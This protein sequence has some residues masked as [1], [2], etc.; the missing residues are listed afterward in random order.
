MAESIQPFWLASARLTSPAELSDWMRSVR[1]QPRWLDEVILFS[2]EQ[3]FAIPP[4]Q[5]LDETVMVTRHFPWHT[6]QLSILHDA[7]RKINSGDRGMILILSVSA[8][9]TTAII[10][11][12]PSKTG[13][14]NMMPLAYMDVRLAL[15][16]PTMNIDI[17]ETIARELAA[18][19]KSASQLHYLAFTSATLKRP[20][21][22]ASPFSGAAWVKSEPGA[23]ASALAACH[24]LVTQLATTKKKH[25]LAFE[26][27]TE[28]NLYAS[29]IEMV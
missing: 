28:S 18:T 2:P 26:I 23:E 29:W 27:D 15:H 8:Q 3:E 9:A 11:C 16:L 21:K 6:S 10:L 4:L 24:D 19:E 22:S 17:L 14:Y 13:M 12:S 25:G 1:I 7:C 5:E 20:V